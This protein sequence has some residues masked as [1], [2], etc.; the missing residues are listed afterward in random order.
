MLT[1][2]VRPD[3]SPR[4]ALR[5]LAALALALPLGCGD[6]ELTGEDAS[7]AAQPDTTATAPDVTTAEPDASRGEP[8]APSPGELSVVSLDDGS[9]LCTP[10]GP[11]PF[12]GVLYNHG[13]LVWP[14]A[15]TSWA[16]AAPS[17]RRATWA[18]ASS[19]A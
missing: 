15:A 2:S 11:G 16:P 19:D 4:R 8:D 12:P 9:T 1:L 18:T 13:G 6:P 3:D 14:S 7:A 10:P 17:R 5:S